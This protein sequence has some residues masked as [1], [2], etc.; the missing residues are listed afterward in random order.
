[1]GVKFI[2]RGSVPWKVSSLAAITWGILLKRWMKW[3]KWKKM[4]WTQSQPLYWGLAWVFPKCS[5]MLR[6]SSS[7]AG[8]CWH[9]FTS[10][11]VFLFISEFLNTAEKYLPLQQGSCSGF[12]GY[13]GVIGAVLRDLLIAVLY[14]CHYLKL[15]GS[16]WP[17][18][19]YGGYFSNVASRSCSEFTSYADVIGAVLRELLIALS[20][21]AASKASHEGLCEIL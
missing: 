1:M 12:T 2:L 3:V 13:A 20:I 5:V 4:R 19:H 17:S 10:V 9:H 8:M 21:M 18:H 15:Y 11:D 7:L 14:S 16:C 6:N